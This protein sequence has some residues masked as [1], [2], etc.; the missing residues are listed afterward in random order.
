MASEASTEASPGLHHGSVRSLHVHTEETWQC[1][2]PLGVER[3]A[4]RTFH[5]C[6]CAT[7]GLLK[8]LQTPPPEPNPLTSY[9]RARQPSTLNPKPST[10]YYR[11]LYRNLKPSTSPKCV[12]ESETEGPRLVRRKLGPAGGCVAIP[13][14]GFWFRV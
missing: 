12:Q 14:F 1:E 4:S 6:L 9:I 7:P 2:E 3:L 8:S 5:S 13:F 10:S 11:S